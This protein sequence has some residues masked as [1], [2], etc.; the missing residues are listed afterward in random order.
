MD[1]RLNTRIDARTIDGRY[2]P[3]A[4]TGR[5]RFLWS[6]RYGARLLAWWGRLGLDA[7]LCLD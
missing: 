3:R 6:W 2:I 1:T 5:P 4:D 7:V